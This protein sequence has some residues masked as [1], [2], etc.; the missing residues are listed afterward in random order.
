MNRAPDW[1]PEIVSLI[2]QSP[3]EIVNWSLNFRNPHRRW[4]S[5]RG[6]V[7]M[8]G[9]AAHA[10]LPSSA[11]GAVQ[12]AEDAVSIAECLRQ[13]GKE[14]IS[15]STQVHNTLRYVRKNKTRHAFQA[16]PHANNH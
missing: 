3:Q 12:A 16:Y 9:D 7:V 1:D 10:F 11:N 5:P 2:R 6:H 13:G 8:I 15:W 14:N 4:T